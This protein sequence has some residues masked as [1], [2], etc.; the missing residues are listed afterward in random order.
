MEE[1]AFLIYESRLG[2]IVPT[3]LMFTPLLMCRCENL[4]VLRIW[5]LGSPGR[6]LHNHHF[7]GK[8]SVQKTIQMTYNQRAKA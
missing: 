1:L 6:Y 4:F 5:E 3:Y 2:V 8:V 7:P